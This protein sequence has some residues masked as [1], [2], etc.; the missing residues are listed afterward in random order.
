[1]SC[2]VNIYLFSCKIT[3]THPGFHI[4]YDHMTITFD[5]M[6]LNTQTVI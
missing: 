3:Y 4:K 1:M 5:P 6:T 2:V